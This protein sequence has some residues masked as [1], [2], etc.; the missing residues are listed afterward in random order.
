MLDSEL[1]NRCRFNLDSPQH[2][3]IAIAIQQE[4]R[5]QDRPC[6]FESVQERLCALSD[7]PLG[8]E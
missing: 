2:D 8:D 3:L 7:C 6:F 4:S 1:C 5:A